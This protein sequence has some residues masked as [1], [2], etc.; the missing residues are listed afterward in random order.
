MEGG[1]S[2]RY[3]N[4]SVCRYGGE[5][6]G[7][8]DEGPH[9]RTRPTRSPTSPLPRFLEIKPGTRYKLL[10]W[11]KRFVISLLNSCKKFGS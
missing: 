4:V 7:H 6:Y 3:G 10:D 8:M 2:S 5:I 1:S 9:G 11:R